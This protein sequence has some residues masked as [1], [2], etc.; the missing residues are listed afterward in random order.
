M[1]DLLKKKA[2]LIS[3]ILVVFLSAYGIYINTDSYKFNSVKDS[4]DYWAVWRYMVENPGSDHAED[5]QRLALALLDA[6][7]RG[8]RVFDL[9][10]DRGRAVV[11]EDYEMLAYVKPGEEPTTSF[12]IGGAG[13]PKHS[14][15]DWEEYKLY[16]LIRHK[17]KFNDI[18]IAGARQGGTDDF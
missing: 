12:V 14:W 11:D 9:M 16:L 10:Y 3:L 18:N 6:A 4:G 13:L 8:Q 5:A 2:F 17:S 7:V 15:A 1:P